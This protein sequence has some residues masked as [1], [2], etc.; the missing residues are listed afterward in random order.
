MNYRIDWKHLLIFIFVCGGLILI[1]RSFM[2]SLGIMLLIL[3]VDYVFA[4]LEVRRRRK[5]NKPEKES[6]R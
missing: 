2:M 4:N 6:E 1:T 5:K 3:V